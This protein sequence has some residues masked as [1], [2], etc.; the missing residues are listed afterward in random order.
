MSSCKPLVEVCPPSGPSPGEGWIWFRCAYDGC[1]PG[2][3][4]II[5]ES[6]DGEI[7]YDG[8]PTESTRKLI[9]LDFPAAKLWEGGLMQVNY[10]LPGCSESGHVCNRST[11]E[12]GS[13]E[14]TA[15]PLGVAYLD[16]AGGPNDR[17]NVCDGAALAVWRSISQGVVPNTPYIESAP[18]WGFD[19]PGNVGA[20]NF[21][22]HILGPYES[23]QWIFT[24]DIS[25]DDDL[26]VDGVK[27]FADGWAN[28]VGGGNVFLKFLPRGAL[29]ASMSGTLAGGRG[30]V[31]LCGF[32]PAEYPAAVVTLRA[33]MPL[34]FLPRRSG[35]TNSIIQAPL[36]A[37]AR[38]ITGREGFLIRC[39]AL[40]PVSSLRGMCRRSRKSRCRLRAG[41][42]LLRRASCRLSEACLGRC[43]SRRGRWLA[44]PRCGGSKYSAMGRK[45]MVFI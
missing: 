32:I 40:M 21:P 41:H 25:A 43:R 24:G 26:M 45:R 37:R 23:D 17:G 28:Q 22:D 3:G 20:S 31:A 10:G 12:W 35:L 7:L 13:Y 39:R 1:H 29:L 27:V 44:M 19:L 16:N 36:M 33:A 6:K 14:D 42:S 15:N 2:V 18:P 9:W 4:H 11:F 5:I 8:C 34:S 30:R 38:F